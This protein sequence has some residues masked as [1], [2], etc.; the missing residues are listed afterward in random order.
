MILTVTMNPCIDKYVYTE[1]ITVG[2]TNRI[3][4]EGMT[5]AGKGINVARALKAMSR[6]V[7]CT[8]INYRENGVML[9]ESLAQG[10]IGEDFAMAHGMLRTNLKIRDK[11][12]NITEINESG[13]SVDEG[14]I[15]SVTEKILKYAEQS[16]VVLLCG[17]LPQGVPAGF[18]GN[19]VYELKKMGK[20][21]VIDADGKALFRGIKES[22]AIIKPNRHEF[23]VLCD[24]KM[25]DVESVVYNAKDIANTHGIGAVAVSLGDKG[26]VITDG[27]RAYYSATLRSKVVS[28]TGAGDAMLAGIT[29]AYTRKLGIEEML[30]F[31]MAAANIAVTKNIDDEF[32]YKRMRSILE[33]FKIEEV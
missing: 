21:C 4:P 28:T 20:A 18:Y 13:S 11:S 8:G 14:A 6:E 29:L 12:G 24:K 1:K 27:R 5:T 15:R 9:T 19:I 25:P 32:D 30:R 7:F 3:T 33:E 17:S 2:E 22:P 26:A 16:E 10:G 31:G 23:E